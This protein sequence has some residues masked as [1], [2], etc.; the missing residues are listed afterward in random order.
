MAN[1]TVHTLPNPFP[2]NLTNNWK[3]FIIQASTSNDVRLDFDF[4]QKKLIPQVDKD[5]YTF[6]SFPK[7]YSSKSGGGNFTEDTD[8]C[9]ARF[10]SPEFN[11]WLE[12]IKICLHQP[13]TYG[14]V[15]VN[16]WNFGPSGSVA[17]NL[18]ELECSQSSDV[19]IPV[20]IGANQKLI[21]NVIDDTDLYMVSSSQI[22][23]LRPFV[24]NDADNIIEGNSL[25]R[26]GIQYA[27]GNAYGLKIFL[28][29]WALE[30][31]LV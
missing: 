3:K 28:V 14:C 10:K 7:P 17:T 4:N 20:T 21:S 8:I 30:C 11:L 18:T 15:K 12:K 31:D 13:T 6:P 24:T 5:T 23:K 1:T 26:F 9:F 16:V 27:E 2:T 29:C 25:L 22:P 19:N